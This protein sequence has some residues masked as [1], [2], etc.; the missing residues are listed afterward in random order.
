MAVILTSKLVKNNIG[1]RW[2]SRESD[3]LYVGVVSPKQ[4]GLRQ[5]AQAGGSLGGQAADRGV[6][7]QLQGQVG[8]VDDPVGAED[9]HFTRLAG[10]IHLQV[11]PSQ[12]TA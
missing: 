3:F 4:D 6:V 9:H 8:L 5:A 2:L 7:L 11:S 12:T 1:D 10:E